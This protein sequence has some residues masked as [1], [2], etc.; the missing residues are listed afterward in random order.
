MICG[1]RERHPNGS[2]SPLNLHKTNLGWSAF[3][4][5]IEEP[6][7]HASRFQQ[8]HWYGF[9]GNLLST[10]IQCVIKAPNPLSSSCF[11]L[12]GLFFIAIDYPRVVETRRS[13]VQLPTNPQIKTNV[14]KPSVSE[15]NTGAMYT[16][17]SS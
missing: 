12:V 13:H 14:I 11:R 15:T 3:P 7:C 1:S 10:L 9:I 6:I 5:A 17:A 16:D 4:F 8:Q 2:P